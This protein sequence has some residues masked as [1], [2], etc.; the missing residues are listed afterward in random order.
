MTG[1]PD[2]AKEAD[3]SGN[4]PPNGARTLPRT[5]DVVYGSDPVFRRC[6]LNVRFARKRTRLGDLC[7]HALSRPPQHRRADQ[8][9]GS[10]QSAARGQAPPS[11]ANPFTGGAICFPRVP[12]AAVATYGLVRRG[13]H[14]AVAPAG[15]YSPAAAAYEA[16]APARDLRNSRTQ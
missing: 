4:A 2:R 6:R 16:A 9:L 7:V 1:E 15:R 8:A 3:A 10:A 12:R 13:W 5:R 14:C 11:S